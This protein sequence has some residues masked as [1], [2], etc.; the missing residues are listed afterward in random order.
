MLPT[1]SARGP[2][3]GRAISMP[4]AT[5]IAERRRRARRRRRDLLSLLLAA[6]D[7]DGR[8][9]DDVSCATRC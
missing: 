9:D 6:R 8:G 7:D 1:P 3:Q 4:C 5:L 2:E